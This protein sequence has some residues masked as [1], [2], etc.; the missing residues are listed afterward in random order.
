MEDLITRALYH[1]LIALPTFYLTDVMYRV[2]NS[3]IA[4]LLVMSLGA[5]MHLMHHVHGAEPTRKSTPISWLSDPM[6]VLS[7]TAVAVRTVLTHG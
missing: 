7:A 1:P 3:V 5:V 6:F 4:A 2:D